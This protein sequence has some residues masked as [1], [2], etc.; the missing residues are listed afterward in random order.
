MGL[1]ALQAMIALESYMLEK[2]DY[3]LIIEDFVSKN[4]QRIKFFK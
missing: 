1:D 4:A 3:V 2:I